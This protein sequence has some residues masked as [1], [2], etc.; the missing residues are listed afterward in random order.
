MVGDTVETAKRRS[1]GVIHRPA[2]LHGFGAPI[3]GLLRG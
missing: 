2:L 3:E 1:V